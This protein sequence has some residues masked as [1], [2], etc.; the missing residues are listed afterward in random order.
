M[1]LLQTLNNSGDI[2]YG[3]LLKGIMTWRDN[4]G[5]DSTMTN[6]GAQL[7]IA[8]CGLF[9][10]IWTASRLYPVIAGEEKLSVLP[11]LRPFAICLVLLNWTAFVDLC[12]IPGKAIEEAF[13]HEFEDKWGELKTKSHE[14]YKMVD[15]ISIK[16]FTVGNNVERAE[17]SERST[18]MQESD[19]SKP[20]GWSVFGVAAQLSALKIF[21]EN[22]FKRLMERMIEYI[23]LLLMNVCVCVVFFMQAVAMIVLIVLGPIAFAFS[24]LD[25]WRSSWTK[26]FA[27]FFSVTLWSGIAWLVCWIGCSIMVEFLNVELD[28]LSN[29][30]SVDLWD[31]A[32]IYSTTQNETF[33]LP[34]IFLFVGFGM[35]I[36][37]PVSTWIIETSGGHQIISAPAA[38]AATTVAVV[39]SGAK[40]AAGGGGK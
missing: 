17:N 33:M 38:A 30:R 36:I 35:F 24:C 27:R 12:R 20:A 19:V 28:Y 7:A 32:A 26:W 9:A 18:Q 1:V 34:L 16:I 39:A 3:D 6:A 15:D 21:I 4:V 37:F 5:I 25:P 11:L 10:F 22:Q 13:M 31:L 2:F 8:M 14:R 40:M 23:C 29:I